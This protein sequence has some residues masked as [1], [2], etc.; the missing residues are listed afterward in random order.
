MLL[1]SLL[2]SSL[3]ILNTVGS[4]NEKV[5]KNIEIFQSI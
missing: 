4:I 3:F 1:L 5:F 2:I